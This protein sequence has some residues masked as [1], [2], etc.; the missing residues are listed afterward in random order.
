MENEHRLFLR[1]DGNYKT[2]SKTSVF[3]T[4]LRDINNEEREYI[5]KTNL[6]D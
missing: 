5:M 1:I 3:G 2:I 6:F 4:H